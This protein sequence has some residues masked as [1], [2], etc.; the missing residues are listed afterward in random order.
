[1]SIFN[2]KWKIQPSAPAEFFELFPEFLN[3]TKQILYNRGF[4]EKH[5]VDKFFN[6]NYDE[7]LHDPYLLKDIKK[8]ATRILGAIKGGENILIYGDYDADGVCASTLLK[9]SLETLGAKNIKVYIPDR[10]DEGYGMNMKAVQKFVKEGVGLIITVDCGSTNKNEIEFAQKHGVDVIVTDHH[11]VLDNPNFAYALVNPQRKD[12]K[13]PFKGLSGTAVAF[14]LV[15][16]LIKEAQKMNWDMLQN[17]GKGGEKWLLDLVAISIVTDV[18]PLVD[19]NRTLVKYG[20]LVL[21]KTRRPGLLELIKKARVDIN[22]IDAYTLGFILGPRLNAAGRMHHANLAFNLLNSKDAKEAGKLVNELEKLNNE[23]RGVVA[24][25]LKDLEARQPESKHAIVEG[26]EDWPIGVLGI[27]AGRLADKYN[28]PTFLYQRKQHTLVGS[29]R[30][31]QNFNT[32]TILASSS[33]YLEKFGGHAQAGGFT[34]SL[35]NEAN[36]QDTILN[37]TEQYVEKMGK[38]STMPV[39]KIDAQLKYNDISWDLYDELVKFKPFGEGNLQPVFLLK[40]AR[41][42]RP[43]MVGQQKNHFRCYITDDTNTT[44]GKKA[45]GFNFPPSSADIKDGDKVDI[46][47]NLDVDEWNGNRELD[48]KLIDIKISK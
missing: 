19:E 35:D 13:Y 43:K 8:A 9:T 5:Q 28:K 42:L 25:I 1:M 17:F 14:K 29:A 18:M 10:H 33:L 2:K 40:N 22:K 21:V 36:L 24:E 16:V 6:P 41:A 27:A 37:I 23:R 48:L 15:Q 20:L 26:H 44:S 7:D 11:Q 32:V 3:T 12:D 30:T 31:P 38:D 47:F 39:I 46:L 45:I 4:K 34:A